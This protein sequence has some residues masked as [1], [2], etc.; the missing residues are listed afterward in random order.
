MISR[1]TS[2]VARGFTRSLAFT[3]PS[4]EDPRLRG[5]TYAIPFEEVWQQCIRLVDGG[6]R[7]WELREADD[8]EGVIRGRIRGLTARFAS[9]LTVRVTLDANA[10]TRV[11]ALA[12]CRSGRYDLGTNVRR[13]NRF[14]RALDRGLEESRGRAIAPVRLAGAESVGHPG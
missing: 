5:R 3:T 11:D 2:A 7:G 10:Q 8:E 9:T 14:F 12:A 1:I 6:L 4:A 13:L